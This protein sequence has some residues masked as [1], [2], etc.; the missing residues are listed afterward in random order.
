MTDE[1]L[2]KVHIDLPHH[3]ATGG[4]SLWAEDL[5]GDRYRLENVPF[6][7]YDLNFHDIVEAR[8]S[9]PDLKPSVLRVLE[10][11]GH[12]TIRVFFREDMSETDK[13]AHLSAL[14]ECHVTFE[15]CSGRYFALDLEPEA[16]VDEVRERLDVLESEGT[17]AYETCEARVPG[18]F[19]AASSEDPAGDDS[20]AS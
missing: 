9:R 12:Q 17:L 10:R 18:S 1:Q 14:T 19:D 8:A 16:P 5:G 15:R 4:E 3:W 2:T 13:L 7:A 6:Y 20:P 11:S